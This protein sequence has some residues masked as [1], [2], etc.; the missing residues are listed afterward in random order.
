MSKIGILGGT[1]DPIH[2][3]HM[4]LA[5]QAITEFKLDKI[6]FIPNH[7]AWMKSGRNITDEKDRVLMVLAS[8]ADHPQF[9]ISYIE[10]EAGGNSYTADTLTALCRDHPENKYYFIMG[11]DSLFTIESWYK[12]DVIFSHA[13]ILVSV[14]D[15]CNEEELITKKQ[16]LKHDFSADIRLLH[17]DKVE[18]SSTYIREHFY[19]DENVKEMLPEAVYRYASEK[20]LYQ[21]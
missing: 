18:I 14:R 7:L 13:V 6:L 8:I 5:E 21:N 3:G 10:I 11:A 4:A 12:P 16:Q 1:F 9:E 15:D 20:H 19:T 2:N 17:M